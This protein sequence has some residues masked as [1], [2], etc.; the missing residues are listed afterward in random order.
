MDVEQRAAAEE[1]S[2]AL[3]MIE[4]QH[5]AALELAESQ[6]SQL[7]DLLANERTAFQ[8]AL[9]EQWS[10][11]I[12]ERSRWRFVAGDQ[13]AEGRPAH[14][15]SDP[16]A[17]EHAEF[18]ELGG[19]PRDRGSGEPAATS[20][21]THTERFVGGGDELKEEERALDRGRR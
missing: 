16:A 9:D 17:A 19:E 13:G 1:R 8:H 4:E 18:D 21:F 15:A 14:Q 6:V 11:S 5:R 10:E 7:S 3:A 20:K 2:Q 12:L